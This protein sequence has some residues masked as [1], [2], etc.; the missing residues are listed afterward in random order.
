MNHLKPCYHF[1]PEKNWM[2]DPNGLI[3][4]NGLYHMFYQ[5]NPYG[6]KWGNIHWGHS[7]SKD[8]IHWKHLPL[9]LKPS[10]Q[11]GEDHCWSGCCFLDSEKNPRLFYTSIGPGDRCPQTGAQQW[12]ATGDK[13]LAEFTQDPEKGLKLDIHGGEEQ[14]IR[15]WRDPFVFH[16]FGKWYVV[17][18]GGFKGRGA[19]FLYESEDLESWDYKGIIYYD[20]IGG[21]FIECPN[22]VK[23]DDKYVLIFSPNSTV[24][25]SIGDFSKDLKFNVEREGTLDFGGWQGFYAPQVFYDRD[26]KPLMFGWLTEVS[27]EGS[28]AIK[29]YCGVQ[30]LPRTLSLR[31]DGFLSVRP[32]DSVKLL[33]LQSTKTDYKLESN[34]VIDL[35]NKS[36]QYE[37]NLSFKPCI[38]NIWRKYP[39]REFGITLL[40]SKTSG[41]KTTIRIFQE[42]HEIRVILDRSE[43][44]L[45]KDIV[46]IPLEMFGIQKQQLCLDLQI[47]VDGSSI[48]IFMNHEYA[49]TGRVYPESSDSVNLSLYC[50]AS[51]YPLDVTGEYYQ[52][53][54]N[55]IMTE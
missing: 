53:K 13:S 30:S 54:N 29:G 4:T 5:Y 6:D 40:E 21:A 17:V 47:F 44:T 35:G 24:R 42:S 32:H 3:Y 33:R 16:E 27:R 26:K 20:K 49:L 46:T 28:E 1:A 45:L 8:L 36:T 41:E 51:D 14:Y 9:A 18:G 37:L 38:D 50:K 25:Y 10:K 2:N 52:L 19:V 39:P 55:V 43:S 22:F 12:M 48:E 7:Q 11:L 15:E 34:T 31:N 23:I